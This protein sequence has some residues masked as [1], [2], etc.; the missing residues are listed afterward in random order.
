MS[1]T[2]IDI[3]P[4]GVEPLTRGQKAWATRKANAAK[5][6]P[7]DP[8]A[9]VKFK[10]VTGA[11]QEEA[12]GRKLLDISDILKLNLQDLINYAESLKV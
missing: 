11:E 1:E 4:K 8:G 12:P 7:E 10:K 3:K 9:S 2:V 5:K 6:K